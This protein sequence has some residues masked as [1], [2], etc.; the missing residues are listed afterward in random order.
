MIGKRPDR[1]RARVLGAAACV[2]SALATGR[3]YSSRNRL[4]RET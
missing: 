1:D 2:A 3:A 4:G